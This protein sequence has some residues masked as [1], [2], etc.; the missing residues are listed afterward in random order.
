MGC[1]AKGSYFSVHHKFSIFEIKY[2]E[3][4]DFFFVS[5]CT[6]LPYSSW[7]T[8]AIWTGSH[9]TPEGSWMDITGELLHML[10]TIYRWWVLAFSSG[11]W[12]IPTT[13][14]DQVLDGRVV[15]THVKIDALCK[16]RWPPEQH[17]GKKCRHILHLLCHQ[18]SLGTVCLQQDSDHMCLWPG[19]H[20][21]GH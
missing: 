5:L 20:L 6:T 3:K 12:N 14:V 15:Q 10:G 7:T 8:S 1:V 4:G 2:V 19:Y 9:C 21:S 16:Q 18:E 17:P 11:L 13:P